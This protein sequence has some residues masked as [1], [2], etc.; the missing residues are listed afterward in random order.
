MQLISYLFV[1]GAMSF[2]RQLKIL[3]DS[4]NLKI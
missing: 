4:T 1:N 2:F 3:Q